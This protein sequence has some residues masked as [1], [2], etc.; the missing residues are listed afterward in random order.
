M[1]KSIRNLVSFHLRHRSALLPTL[2]Q[3]LSLLPASQST[4]SFFIP[5]AEQIEKDLPS[6]FLDVSSLETAM[7]QAA[8]LLQSSLTSPHSK[9]ELLQILSSL[10]FLLCI[11]S[12]SFLPSPSL[13][14]LL[15]ER[16]VRFMEQVLL[17]IESFNHSHPPLVIPP[18]DFFA[19]LLYLDLFSTSTQ[20]LIAQFLR[21]Q[22]VEPL[23]P[24]F[25]AVSQSNAANQFDHFV[26]RVLADTSADQFNFV[27]PTIQK[28]F[29][30]LIQFWVTEIRRMRIDGNRRDFF[31][32]NWVLLIMKKS[33]V[34]LDSAFFKPI[35]NAFFP[36][37][38]STESGFVQDTDVGPFFGIVKIGTSFVS[39]NRSESW[40][41][42]NSLSVGCYQLQK[43][44]LFSHPQTIRNH[45]GVVS[46]SAVSS[47]AKA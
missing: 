30:A 33:A 22:S 38:L 18:S 27:L 20:S 17:R 9:N 41:F 47:A 39:V 10:Q 40:V 29:N 43:K 46:I 36:S 25:T 12:S 44:R 5:L 13:L 4:L 3:F 16:S 6:S 37:L 23:F 35:L 7:K 11:V 34:F 45:L 32:M 31:L 19:F 14:I 1:E 42:R 28:N 2:L 21:L 15:G 26:V 24:L 8:D